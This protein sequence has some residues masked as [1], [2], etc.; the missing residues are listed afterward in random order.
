[1][2][3][4]RRN[5]VAAF[6]CSGGELRFGWYSLQRR[7]A[8]LWPCS[9]KALGGSY[10]AQQL[11]QREL[12]KTL[13]QPVSLS[14]IARGDYREQAKDIHIVTTTDGNHGRSVAWGCRLF[15][16]SCHIYIHAKAALKRWRL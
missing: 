12:S 16:A 14:G 11:L 13:G 6:A 5:S 1:M 3:R 7:R 15:G 2:G 10:A 9:F 8:T 4:V